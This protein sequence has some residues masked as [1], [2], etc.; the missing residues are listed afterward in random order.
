MTLPL[1]LEAA[2]RCP[3][4]RGTL[5]GVDARPECE[6]CSAEYS[7]R[8]GEIV[9]L[10]PRADAVKSEPSFYDA[11]DPSRYGRTHMADPFVRQ[12]RSFVNCIPEDGL[13]L[14][15]GSGAGA[16]QDIQPGYVASDFSFFALERYSRGPRVQADATALPFADESLDG[17]LTRATLEHVPDP[18]RALGEIDRCL[19]P[20]GSALVYP[21]WF[22]RPWASKALHVRPYGEL[23]TG[24]RL[25][26]V[27][28]PAREL[29]AYRFAR[30]LPG[31]VRRERAL[32]RGARSLPFEYRALEPNLE[33]FLAS[34]SDAFSSMDPQ[35]A[36]AFFLSRGY[37]DETRPT[38]LRRLLY[39]HE[40]MVVVKAPPAPS[41]P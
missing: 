2:L 15:I 10:R 36:S 37:R 40:P 41:P 6:R 33:E 31:R 11:P 18:G 9:R 1:K 34:D 27:S 12:V 3:V 16:L 35:A 32:R 17:V 22:V 14:E 24:D 29:K 20:G 5:K 8:E 30:I 38:P 39:A 28:I 25:R 7:P 26:K 13:L 21:S 4:C 23:S 19:K